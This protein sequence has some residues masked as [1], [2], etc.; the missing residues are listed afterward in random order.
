MTGCLK[1]C[2]GQGVAADRPRSSWENL[3]P[4]PPPAYGEPGKSKARRRC[5][6]LLIQKIR[7]FSLLRG[8]SHP[9]PG[10]SRLK[11]VS[12]R[13]KKRDRERLDHGCRPCR[14]RVVF[15][16]FQ[17]LHI[18]RQGWRASAHKR[19]MALD[20]VRGD[21]GDMAEGNDI[22]VALFFVRV[23]SMGVCSWPAPCRFRCTDL[24][25]AVVQIGRR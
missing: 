18:L 16:L 13:L 1:C 19:G 17:Q 21:R 24:R 6:G 9:G 25:R 7:H 14:R 23:C 11:P 8:T 4:P 2:Q 3:N 15:A 12:S 22:R 10:T 5:E 20:R